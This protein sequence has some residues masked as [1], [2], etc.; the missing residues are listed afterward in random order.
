MLELQYFLAFIAEFDDAVP[1]PAID[2]IYG[3]GTEEAVRSFQRARGLTA[4][5]IAGRATWNAIHD[6]YR[7]IIAYLYGE[8]TVRKI[9]PYPGMVLKRGMDGPSVQLVQQELSYISR[10][11]Y[12]IAPLPDTGY[13]GAR[14]EDSVERFQ[15]L[16]GLPVTGMVDEATWNRIGEM[17]AV[18]VLGDRRLEG[19]FPG[20][21]IEGR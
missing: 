5:G 18:L 15:E 17:A 6:A 12:E 10:F 20:Y 21:I 8:E 16:F 4:D 19:Q 13:F 7:G 11:L 1:T 2:G 3:A 14:T 9:E